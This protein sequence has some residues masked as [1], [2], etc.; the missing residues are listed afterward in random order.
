MHESDNTR[1]FSKIA[2]RYD[3]LNH[4]LSLNIDRLWRRWAVA[5][6]A[7]PPGGRVLDV[8]AGT[9][10][11]SVGF[12]RYTKASVIVG[13]D[14]SQE[15]IRVGLGKTAGRRIHWVEGDVMDLP[16][17]EGVFDAVANAFGLR[18]LADY[19]HG[20]IEM[21][22]VLRPGG[23]LVI[24][25]FAPPSDGLFQRAYRAYLQVMVPAIGTLVSGDDGAYRYLASSVGGFLGCDRVLEIMRA[26]GL[27]RTRARRL[28]GGIAYIY[29]GTK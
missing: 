28:T 3:L 9:G 29:S 20:V 8:C 27:R 23:R 22:R 15:M 16:F 17:E 25:E 4:V 14:L 6:A 5:T 10:D 12:A 13:V 11:V 24:L 19:D 1:M 18:N 26:A 2:R 21:A 7:L